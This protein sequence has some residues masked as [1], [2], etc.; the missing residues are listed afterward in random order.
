MQSPLCLQ[1]IAP[2]N[3]EDALCWGCLSSIYEVMHVNDLS[4]RLVSVGATLLLLSGCQMM[5]QNMVTADS[6]KQTFE[7]YVKTISEHPEKYE[8]GNVAAYP[9][10]EQYAKTL[11]ACQEKGYLT[12]MDM[13]KA[14]AKVGGATQEELKELEG[15]AV[16]GQQAMEQAKAA[17]QTVEVEMKEAEA[18]MK[19]M[20]QEMQQATEDTSQ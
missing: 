3:R 5:P 1:G 16:Y 10:L 17:A 14:T 6:C 9:E 2:R 11:S 7:S 4:K 8:A 19:A 20:Q 12:A 18:A 15:A 13:M